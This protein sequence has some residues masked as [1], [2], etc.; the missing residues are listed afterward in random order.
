MFTN[1]KIQFFLFVFFQRDLDRKV[2][3]ATAQAF[4]IQAESIFNRISQDGKEFFDE[5]QLLN[6][7][8][9]YRINKT[10][11][12]TDLIIVVS[13]LSSRSCSTC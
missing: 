2:M 9:L 3:M 13:L 1:M 8:S 12:F 11:C 5:M 6:K 7:I 10:C 4:D